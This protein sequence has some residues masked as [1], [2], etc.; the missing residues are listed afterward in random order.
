MRVGYRDL[1]LIRDL[2]LV[3]SLD[4]LPPLCTLPP[5]NSGNL[6]L[7]I[8]RYWM[9]SFTPVF[10]HFRRQSLDDSPSLFSLRCGIRQPHPLAIVGH[11][12][13]TARMKSSCLPAQS[14]NCMS[15]LLPPCIPQSWLTFHV[16]CISR[17]QRARFRGLD[18]VQPVGR[19]DFRKPLLS[20]YKT[21]SMSISAIPPFSPPS[22]P[23]C[24]S[25]R[26]QPMCND[27]T[28]QGTPRRPVQDKGRDC[29]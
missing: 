12:S 11:E 21:P 19:P 29:F 20:G 18:T 25:A 27:F 26:S 9:C 23:R 28:T 2:S 15:A 17:V 14:L 6:Y 24:Q 16:S 1:R 8:P 3:E 4:I 22:R 5:D 13:M 7:M 10:L